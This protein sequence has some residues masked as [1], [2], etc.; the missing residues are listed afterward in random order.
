MIN[1]F[2]FDILLFDQIYHFVKS[3]NVCNP[4]N[5]L[6]ILYE[7]LFDFL[8][9]DSL[10][11]WKDCTMRMWPAHFLKYVLTFFTWCKNFI[12]SF[13]NA[14][15]SIRHEIVRVGKKKNI[16]MPFVGLMISFSLAGIGFFYLIQ[17]I[18][19][20]KSFRSV[21]VYF[22]CPYYVCSSNL[23]SFLI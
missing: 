2:A 12:T 19:F 10:D 18:A 6:N 23:F 4:M 11:L 17:N 13:C 16:I 21:A 5:F 22:L 14:L 3:I 7:W 9:F 8:V 20:K 1:C 15:S